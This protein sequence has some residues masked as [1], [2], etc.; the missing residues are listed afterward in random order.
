MPSS[1][2]FHSTT[3]LAYAG[4]AAAVPGASAAPATAAAASEVGMSLD[5]GS[6]GDGV[7]NASTTLPRSSLDDRRPQRQ[8]PEPHAALDRAE[9]RAGRAGD[10]GVAEAGPVLEQQ[11]LGL[12]ARQHAEQAPRSRRLQRVLVGA[13]ARFRAVR[14]T[15]DALARARAAKSVDRAAVRYEEEVGAQRAALGPVAL[16]PREQR[17]EDVLGDVLGVGAVAEHAVG[18]G[19][20]GGVMVAEGS[21]DVEHSRSPGSYLLRVIVLSRLAGSTPIPRSPPMRRLLLSLTAPAAIALIV[22]GCGGGSGSTGGTGGYG[23]GSTAP[24]KSTVTSRPSPLGTVLV[25]ANGRTI[26]LFEN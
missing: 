26:Y 5:N 4:C 17:G 21:V 7:V 18:G 25:G 1:A 8:L 24:A 16:R 20:D 13:R 10:R 22:A 12:R 15:P 2:R 19:E 3:G 6:S 14:Q 9:R 23:G 11:R